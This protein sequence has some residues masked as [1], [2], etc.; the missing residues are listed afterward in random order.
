M[1]NVKVSGR[2]VIFGV[3]GSTV[4]YDVETGARRWQRSG[5]LTSTTSPIL[6]TTS[7]ILWQR[8]E[9]DRIITYATS[10]GHCLG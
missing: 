7:P 2:T 1:S 9:G 6:W 3:G 4:A 8:P 5:V 10:R